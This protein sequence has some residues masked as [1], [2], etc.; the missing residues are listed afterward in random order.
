MKQITFILC[1]LCF[2]IGLAQHTGK[3][4]CAFQ[5]DNK[6]WILKYKNTETKEDKVQLVIDKIILD[7]YTVIESSDSADIDGTKSFDKNSCSPKCMIRFGLIY[8]K[9]KGLVLD[10]K[11]NPELE[12]LVLEFNAENISHMDLNE[13]QEKDI[14]SPAALKRSGIVLYTE[15]RDLKKMIRKAIKKIGKR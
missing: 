13:Y 9:K 6:A 5:P 1:L 3:G 8:D 2:G 12:A 14:Y 7:G 4:E 11:K 15:D 10:L